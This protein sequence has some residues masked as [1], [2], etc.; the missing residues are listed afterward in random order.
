[1]IESFVRSESWITEVLRINSYIGGINE[2][3][4]G[5]LLLYEI[6]LGVCCEEVIKT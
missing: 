3:K 5:Y 2:V 6:L 4:F 1:M